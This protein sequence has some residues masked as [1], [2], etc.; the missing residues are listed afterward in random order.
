MFADFRKAELDYIKAQQPVRGHNAWIYGLP[1]DDR[2]HTQQTPLN[3]DAPVLQ[4]H[5]VVPFLLW[6]QGQTRSN[7]TKL[8]SAYTQ[9]QTRGRIGFGSSETSY[10]AARRHFSKLARFV[11]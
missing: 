9:M 4:G 8:Q 7:W 6:N 11:R 2:S 10:M 5:E 3:I 1:Q